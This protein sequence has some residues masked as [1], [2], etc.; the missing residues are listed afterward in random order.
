[1]V[2]GGSK[3]L[4]AVDIV[5]ETDNFGRVALECVKF[6]SFLDVP[7]LSCSIH[8]T[9]GYEF[10]LRI[11]GNTDDLHSVALECV[12]KFSGGSVPE[13]SGTIERAGDDFVSRTMTVRLRYP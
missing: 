9:G 4:V 6:G 10:A 7:E 11:E 3:D 12:E 13:F 2:K 8:R 5:V 1:M